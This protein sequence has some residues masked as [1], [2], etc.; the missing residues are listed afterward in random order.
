MT[1]ILIETS[2]SKYDSIIDV[3]RNYYYELPKAIHKTDKE[4]ISFNFYYSGYAKQYFIKITK[5]HYTIKTSNFT[6][7][8]FI[9]STFDNNRPVRVPITDKVKRFNKNLFIKLLNS[10]IDRIPEFIDLVDD[11][12]NYTYETQP[13]KA[14]LY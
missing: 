5:D 13:L 3:G 1:A 11:H 4:L 2:K 7:K 14:S 9:V 10:M 6:G 8:E 12:I